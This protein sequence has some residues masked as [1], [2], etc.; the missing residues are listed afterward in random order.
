M[1]KNALSRREFLRGAAAAG[2]M[3]T[4]SL[5]GITKASAEEIPAAYIPGT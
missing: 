2:L 1:A 3:A 5:L 4:G